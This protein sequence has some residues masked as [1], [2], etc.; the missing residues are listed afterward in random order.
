MARICTVC[1]HKD[2]KKID[3]ALVE[4]IDP[5]DKI[6]KD[7]SL[8]TS[9]LNRHIASGHIK[10]KVKKAV[11]RDS[12]K[13]GADIMGMITEAYNETKVILKECRE[14]KIATLKNGQTKEIPPDNDMALKALARIE[15]QIEIIGKL[16][17][18][19]T[20][21]REI[22]GAIAINI[23]KDDINL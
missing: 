21:K 15:K 13:E 8:S 2:I 5:I 1:A 3:R 17:G 7:Y 10:E 23:D 11:E 16:L 9:A 12:A 18:A 6:S 4:R 14:T 22:T 19:F 20:E